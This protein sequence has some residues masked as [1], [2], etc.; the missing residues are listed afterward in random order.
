MKKETIIVAGGTGQ[1]MGSTT[2]K[3]FLPLKGE[4]ILMRTISLFHSFDASMKIILT[5]P[6]HEIQTWH[7]LCQQKKFT[8]PHT[9]VAGGETRFHSVKNGLAKVSGKG[10]V[11][12]HDGVRPLVTTETIKKAFEEARKSGSAI[13][14]SDI[15]E[16]L[17]YVNDNENYPVSR[18]YYKTIQ[19]PQVFKSELILEA[20]KTDYREQFT[21]DASVVEF[22]GGKISLIKGNPENI[23]IT[24]KKDLVVAEVLLRF[25]S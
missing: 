1:R 5:L 24:T 25:V 4:I 14:Y 7:K 19:T 21:D 6:E 11:A 9:T 12:V 20:Y 2:P 3:Q 23:K 13:P 10:L 18:D 8:V 16:S 17:R 22:G 15:H